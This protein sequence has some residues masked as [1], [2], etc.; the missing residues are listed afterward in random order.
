MHLNLELSLEELIERN[1]RLHDERKI[2]T[3]TL[4]QEKNVIQRP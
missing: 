3:A 4:E 2:K 1:T